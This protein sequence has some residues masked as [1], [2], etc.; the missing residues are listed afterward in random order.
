MVEPPR[1]FPPPWRV[2]K[3]V[4]GYVARDANAQAIA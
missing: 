2:D 4:G 1:G 3:I